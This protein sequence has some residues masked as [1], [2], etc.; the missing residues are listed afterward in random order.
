MASSGRNS[1]RYFHNGKI[2]DAST[3]EEA[4][5]TPHGTPRYASGGPRGG[6][7]ARAHIWIGPP[8]PLSPMWV[9]SYKFNKKRP[10]GLCAQSDQ[11]SQVDFGDYQE[12]KRLR[13]AAY[14]VA[15]QSSAD[16]LA[17]SCA[18]SSVCGESTLSW[19]YKE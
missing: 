13:L 15:G 4:T 1:V 8:A 7:D 3:F 12:A 19:T 18:S 2:S 16:V 14:V 6:D 5:H 9:E 11:A 10:W 17:V